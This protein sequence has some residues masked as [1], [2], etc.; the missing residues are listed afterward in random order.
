MSYI[1]DLML[2]RKRKFALPLAHHRKSRARVDS[3]GFRNTWPF[4][5]TPALS[6]EA[7]TVF[8]QI[9]LQFLADRD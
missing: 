3:E 9:K 1:R 6:P 4:Y 8:Y 5:A 2:I 7:A